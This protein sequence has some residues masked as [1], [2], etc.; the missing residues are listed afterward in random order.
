M[1]GICEELIRNLDLNASVGSRC[2]ER[3][4]KIYRCL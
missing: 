4:E 1:E 3:E 2:K